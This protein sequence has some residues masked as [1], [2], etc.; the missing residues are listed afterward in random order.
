MKEIKAS[1]I[2]NGE[3]KSYIEN[4]LICRFSA[5]N[6]QGLTAMPSFCDVHVHF[7]EPG[8]SYKETITTGCNAGAHGGFT[9]VFTMP[10]L[11][12]VPDSVENLKVQLDLIKE[13]ASINV[14]PYASITI[15]ERGE[16]L[17]DIKALSKYAIAFSDDGRGVQSS[18]MMEDAMRLAKENGKLICAH[19][20]DNSLLFGGYIHKGSYAEKN[21][22]RGICSESEYGQIARDLELVA[23]T[24]VSYHVCHI[25]TKESVEIIRQAKKSGLDVSS[26]TAPHYLI[27][28]DKDLKEEGRYKMNPP[29][30]DES[31]KLALIDGVVDGTIEIIATDHAPHSQEEKSKGL[32]K[33]A[34]GVVGLETSFSASYTH[35]V[36]TK[37]ITLEKLVELMAIN[38]RKRFNLP[39][40]KGFTVFDLDSEYLVNPTEFLSKGKATPFENMKFNGVCKLTALGGKTVYQN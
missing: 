2:A 16:T 37:I 6:K 9:T 31:D 11:N 22:H 21:G 38:P 18:K 3:I 35:L 20:E 36:K 12:P 5:Y 1:V 26:E 23:K 13:Q 15:G 32:E 27:L 39:Y 24:G 28:S 14:Y 4:E 8:F 7:R 10:N 19:C 17:T 34:F 40:D 25:S 29:L 33:S 30:R